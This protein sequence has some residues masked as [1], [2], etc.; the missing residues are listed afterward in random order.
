VAVLVALAVTGVAVA[1]PGAFRRSAH[2]DQAVMPRGCGSCHVGHGAP[3]TDMMS[4][5]RSATCLACHGGSAARRAAK[6]RR[7][8]TRTEGLTD[9]STAFDKRSHHPLGESRKRSRLSARRDRRGAPRAALSTV[10]CTDCHDPHYGAKSS[11]RRSRADFKRTKQIANSRGQARPEYKLCYRCHGSGALAVRGKENIERLVKPANSSFH[12]VEATGRN[13]DVPSL[14]APYDEQSILA[15]TDCHGND[16]QGGP[17]G[18]H[19]S[20]HE[21]ILKAHFGREDGRLESAYQ[22]ALCYRCHN[23]SVV[24]GTTSFPEHRRHVAEVKTSCHTCHNSHG[25]RQYPH[26]ID[27]DAKTVFSNSKGRLR[28]R[29]SGTRR[30]E[31]SLRCHGHD[32][33]AVGY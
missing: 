24:F 13:T 12:P 6:R 10:S 15:C 27:F 18:P 9:V 3:E 8:L 29:S 30:G 32:H 7:L 2:G 17:R 20:A 23:R 25:S 11:R 21:P 26:L 1:A 33:D 4:G 14:I 19:G 22:Y 16:R 5:S 31:C 28:Y